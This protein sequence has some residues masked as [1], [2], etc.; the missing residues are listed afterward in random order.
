MNKVILSGRLTTDGEIRTTSS[1]K[2][3]YSGTL[4]VKRTHKNAEGEYES[5]FFN[6]VLWNPMDY[7]KNYAKKG[8]RAL[9]EGKIQQRSYE[10]KDKNKKY[11]TEIMVENME[12]YDTKRQETTQVPQNDKSEYDNLGSDIQIE[13]KDLP[14]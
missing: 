3:V 4:A 12:V 1:N 11:I 14:F 9:V 2:K 6:L 13:D 10:D 5:D 8:V 7:I